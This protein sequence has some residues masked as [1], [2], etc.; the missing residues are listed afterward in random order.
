MKRFWAIAIAL[1]LW[2]LMGD[3]A[4]VMQVGADPARIDD[5]VTAQAFAAMPPWAWGAY[6]I[7]VWVG[8]AGALALLLRRKAAW[9]LFALSLVGVVVQFGWTI[10]GF[11]ILSYKGPEALVFPVVI[12]LIGAFATVYAYYKKADRTLR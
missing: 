3:A 4:Y 10:F 1:L 11:G 9:V 12:A 7:A 2:N 8:T 5:P 6:A